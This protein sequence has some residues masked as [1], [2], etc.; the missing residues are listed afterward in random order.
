MVEKTLNKESMF[1][2]I[3]DTKSKI[4]YADD[5][6]CKISGFAKDELEGQLHNIVKDN[7]SPKYMFKILWEYI[8]NGKPAV[9]Y[10]RN[11]TKDDNFYWV[12]SVTFPVKDIENKT[13]AYLSIRISPEGKYF[14]KIKN[15]YKKFIKIEEEN[16]DCYEELC[17]KKMQEFL[18]SLEYNSYE[19]F[20]KDILKN[21]IELKDGILVPKINL[22]KASIHMKNILDFIDNLSKSMLHFID[23]VNE[24][25]SIMQDIDK[26]SSNSNMILEDIVLSALNSELVANKFGSEGEAFKVVTSFVKDFSEESSG[27]LNL[28]SSIVQDI[29]D[30]SESKQLIYVNVQ[31]LYLTSILVQREIK[32]YIDNHKSDFVA[33]KY[34]RNISIYAIDVVPFRDIIVN[35]LKLNKKI[36]S[37]ISNIKSLSILGQIEGKNQDNKDFLDI[38]QSLN[39]GS[40]ELELNSDNLLDNI[41]QFRILI[42]KLCIINVNF[43]KR[44]IMQTIE[45]MAYDHEKFVDHIKDLAKNEKVEKV[46][47]HKECNLGQYY[48]GDLKPALTKYTNKECLNVYKNIERFHIEIHKIGAEI[49]ENVSNKD[50]V[51]ELIPKLTEVK[52]LVIGQ[53]RELQEAIEDSS[54]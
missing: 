32:E 51:K 15:L 2:S 4:I 28:V 5:M 12:L 52:D 1:F 36:K 21:E 50:K 33:V 24:S 35:L 47:T 34:F 17:E 14:H 8:E 31:V 3:T 27:S 6:F 53:L 9:M 20:M 10:I 46:S 29:R 49:V 7:N 19:E 43:V 30:E 37:Q 38:M 18:T 25:V 45:I 40:N 22:S 11:K 54:E 42:R 41:E 48:Y 26:N 39:N 44:A 13:L 16:E 23:N